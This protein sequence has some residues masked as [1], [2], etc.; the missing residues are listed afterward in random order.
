MEYYINEVYDVYGYADF[1]HDGRV[2]VRMGL[3]VLADRLAGTGLIAMR[4]IEMRGIR[5]STV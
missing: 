4:D 2:C 5:C 1:V 3:G